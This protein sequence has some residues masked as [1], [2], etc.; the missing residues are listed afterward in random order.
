L[1]V[2]SLVLFLVDLITHFLLRGFEVFLNFFQEHLYGR[3]LIPISCT[4]AYEREGCVHK[5]TLYFKGRLETH[6]FLWRGRNTKI[7]G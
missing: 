1:I 6:T 3:F 5:K 2:F 7:N 4:Q